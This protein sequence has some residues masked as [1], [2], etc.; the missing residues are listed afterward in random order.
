MDVFEFEASLD[1]IVS[2]SLVKATYIHIQNEQTKTNPKQKSQNKTK[3]NQPTQTKATTNFT[4]L[5]PWWNMECGVTV[6]FSGS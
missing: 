4:K 1:S 5:L 6:I 3:T 2:S